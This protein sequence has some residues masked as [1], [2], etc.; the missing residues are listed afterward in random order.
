M[1]YSNIDGIICCDNTELLDKVCSKYYL[2]YSNKCNNIYHLWSNMRDMDNKVIDDIRHACR[3]ISLT[4]LDSCG[5]Y[6]RVTDTDIEPAYSVL[7][8]DVE[9]YLLNYEEFTLDNILEA[10]KVRDLQWMK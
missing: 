4:C 1:S 3:D 9:D 8:S 10:L 2:Q 5:K 6:Y 7:W